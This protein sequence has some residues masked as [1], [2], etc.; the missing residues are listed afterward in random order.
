MLLCSVQS[1]SSLDTATLAVSIN[2]LPPYNV[3]ISGAFAAIVL[4]G[5]AIKVLGLFAFRQRLRSS[6]LSCVVYNYY[7][8][9]SACNDCFFPRSAYASIVANVSIQ[10]YEG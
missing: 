3:R 7:L 2:S 9:V 10:M 1:I 4:L 8:F 6:F 5:Q